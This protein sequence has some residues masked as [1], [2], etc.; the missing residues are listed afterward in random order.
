MNWIN[1]ANTFEYNIFI[2]MSNISLKKMSYDYMIY[3]T[4][5]AT[6]VVSLS[7]QMILC[8]YLYILPF[9]C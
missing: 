9:R 3:E 2:I 5:Y 4:I 6:W 8:F 1:H 7:M